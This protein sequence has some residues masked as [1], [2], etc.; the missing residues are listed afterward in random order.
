MNKATLFK[1]FERIG[2]WEGISFLVLLGI[3][4]PLKY[5]WG[6]PQAV[7]VV[8]MAHGILFIAYLYMIHACRIAFG[9]SLKTAALGALA[10]VMP[11]GP[12]VYDR[13]VKKLMGEEN[14]KVD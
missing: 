9:W 7:S 11:F 4:M 13:W 3:A 14:V 8:G 1:W 12:F 2:T 6:I 5:I 10:S